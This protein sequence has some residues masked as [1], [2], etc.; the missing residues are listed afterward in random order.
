M[1]I[2]A[3]L[4]ARSPKGHRTDIMMQASSKLTSIRPECPKIALVCLSRGNLNIFTRHA[5]RLDVKI[6][7]QRGGVPV[8]FPYTKKKHKLVGIYDIF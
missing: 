1:K 8:I 4:I 3:R 2:G 5:G 7:L 6:M